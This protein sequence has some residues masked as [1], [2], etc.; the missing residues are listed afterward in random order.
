M[1]EDSIPPDI[2]QMSFE[3]ALEE[4]QGALFEIREAERLRDESGLS[5]EGA[6]IAS[7]RLWRQSV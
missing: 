3:Q 2:R 7:R 1:A 5:V 6:A 4:L